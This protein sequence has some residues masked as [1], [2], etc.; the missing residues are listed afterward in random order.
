MLLMPSSLYCQ[1]DTGV[2]G[3]I[4]VQGDFN[5]D[6]ILDYAVLRASTGTWYIHYFNRPSF[7]DTFSFGIAGDVP[8]VG[9]YDGDGISDI[10]VYRPS[11]GEWFIRP[12]R[13]PNTT[14]VKQ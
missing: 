9:D 3:D 6:G 7:V 2:S 12:S 8:V 10:A 5:G 14:T 13:N 11:T 4:R 1:S